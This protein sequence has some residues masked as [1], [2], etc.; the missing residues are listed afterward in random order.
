[1]LPPGR[2]WQGSLIGVCENRRPNPKVW[3]SGAWHSDHGFLTIGD[4]ESKLELAHRHG[5]SL[6]FVPDSQLE[7]ARL[8]SAR[9]GIEVRGLQQGSTEVHKAARDYLRVLSVPP[10]LN[11]PIEER[12]AWYLSID[13]Q[14]EAEEYH[15]ACLLDELVGRCRDRSPTIAALGTPEWHVV[16]AD[17]VPLVEFLVKTLRPQNCLILHTTGPTSSDDKTKSA[18]QTSDRLATFMSADRVHVAPVGDVDAIWESTPSSV[19]EYIDSAAP[20]Q[21]VLD[22][23]PGTKLMSLALAMNVAKDGY[24]TVYLKHRF[25]PF[26]RRRRIPDSEQYMIWRGFGLRSP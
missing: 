3:S 18:E 7:A 24:T 4:L 12:S 11:D 14:E 9:L 23:T 22:L 2:P 15:R 10:G 21:V 8:D 5:A 16:F 25:T 19:R 1:M 20:A 17:N 26:P 13:G 6:F